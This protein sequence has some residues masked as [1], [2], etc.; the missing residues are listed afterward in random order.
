MST[1]LFPFSAWPFLIPRTQRGRP[2][3]QVGLE[4]VEQR[5]RQAATPCLSRPEHADWECSWLGINDLLTKLHFQYTEQWSSTLTAMG[6]SERRQSHGVPD[7]EPTESR[8][9]G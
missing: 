9:L 4:S 8:R 7:R 6:R 5:A 3:A 1:D 2:S